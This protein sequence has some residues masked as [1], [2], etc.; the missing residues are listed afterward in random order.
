MDTTSLC[1]DCGILFTEKWILKE[2]NRVAH[3]EKVLKCDHCSVELV[4]K[5]KII[6]RY[7]P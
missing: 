5:Y 6:K 3:D 2:H 1:Q 7:T 4:E